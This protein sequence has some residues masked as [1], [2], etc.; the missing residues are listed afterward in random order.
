MGLWP[1]MIGALAVRLVVGLGVGIA[2]ALGPLWM[3]GQAKDKAARLE[4]D[5]DSTKAALVDV[6]QRLDEA[7][8]HIESQNQGILD[9]ETKGRELKLQLGEASR[10]N[11]QLSRKH[12]ET[13][14]ELYKA[15]VPA[16]AVGAMDWQKAELL[17]IKE[18]LK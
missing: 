15:Q 10:I 4:A 1:D 3:Y 18:V 14:K 2:G 9:L 5:L 8:S 13:L 7:A 16:D 11:S 17:K 12:Y 6:R